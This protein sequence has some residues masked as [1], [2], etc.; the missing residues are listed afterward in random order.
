MKKFIYTLFL[1]SIF[2]SLILRYRL[3]YKWIDILYHTL[4]ITILI[5]GLFIVNILLTLINKERIRNILTNVLNY[6]FFLLFSSFY[7]LVISSNLFWGKTIT[8]KILSNYIGSIDKLISILPIKAW[9]FYASIIC[10]LLLLTTCFILIRPKPSIIFTTH[11]RLLKNKRV[12]YFTLLFPF[13]L[14]LIIFLFPNP[15]LYVKRRIHFTDEPLFQFILGP[16]WNAHAVPLAF[17]TERYKLGQKDFPCTNSISSNSPQTD[18]TTIVVILLDALRSDHLS[19]YGYPRKTTPFLDSLVNTGNLHVVKNA[20]SNSNMTSGGVS[21]LF[22]SRDW[23]DF[24]YNGLSLMKFM[25]KINYNTYAFLTGFHRDWYDLSALY[26]G[27]CDYYYESA[28]NPYANDDNDLPTLGEIKK[29]S[30]PKNSFIYIHLLST[31]TIGKKNKEF[32]KFLPDKIDIGISGK[33]ALMNN[34]DNGIVQGDYVIS[35][36]FSKL[37][38]DG[39]LS[40]SIIY[41]VA[42]HGELFGEDGRWS[43]GGSIHEQLLNIPM[44]IYDTKRSFY[45]NL[46]SATIKDVAPTIVDRLNYKIPDCW[47]GVSLHQPNHDFSIKVNSGI[48]CDFPKAILTKKDSI[49]T[50]S[51]MNEKNEVKKKTTTKGL[52]SGWTTAPIQ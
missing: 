11:A 37:K 3:N 23:E 36:I 27:N 2:A 24:G 30:F 20:F 40:N 50:L 34:Y 6:A 35:E 46:E 15:F 48:K 39:L 25:K 4:L 49:F 17:D 16:M 21:G 10:L 45:N 19:M 8:L 52:G 22:F 26:R 33:T 38:N 51:I 12:K 14:S 42:D 29:T 32:R 43:H 9:I 18:S 28:I 13:F 5:S 47:Q 1:L 41:I 7:L 31:H 44:L